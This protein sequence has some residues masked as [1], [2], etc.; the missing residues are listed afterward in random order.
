MLVQEF[1]KPIILLGATHTYQV[2][3]S[4]AQFGTLASNNQISVSSTS[5]S[6]HAHNVTVQCA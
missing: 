6:G 5:D 3:I 2:T 1:R 4:T